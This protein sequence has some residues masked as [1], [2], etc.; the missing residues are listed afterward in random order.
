MTSNLKDKTALITGGGTGVGRA[1]TLMLA[2][3]D[4]SVAVNYSKSQKEAEATVAEAKQL[5]VRAMAVQ[6][7][8][9][10]DAQVQRMVDR[11]KQELGAV[12]ILINN[13]AF[14]RFTD[15]SDLHALS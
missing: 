12:D 7:D 11:V 15:L 2:Q 9:A 6:A 14:T 8:V 13:A 3:L 4:A 5:G 10:D 1:I